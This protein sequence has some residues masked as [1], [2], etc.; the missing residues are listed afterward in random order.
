MEY[1]KTITPVDQEILKFVSSII[2]L[3]FAKSDAISK[4]RGHLGQE[5]LGDLVKGN[6]GSEAIAKNRVKSLDWIWEN[7]SRCTNW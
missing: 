7:T 3:E 1:E 4:A 5:L 2:A 6:I